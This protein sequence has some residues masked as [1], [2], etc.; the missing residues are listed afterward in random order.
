M[1]QFMIDIMINLT[2]ETQVLK[3]SKHGI[4]HSSLTCE[5]RAQKA[6]VS[7]K[8]LKYPIKLCRPPDT[9]IIKNLFSYFLTK[10]YVVGT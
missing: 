10:T 6:Y 2:G 1:L 3:A 4:H 7:H 8:P 5:K 9:Y